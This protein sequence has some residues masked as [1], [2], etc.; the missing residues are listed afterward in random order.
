MGRSMLQ[1]EWS[2]FLWPRTDPIIRIDWAAISNSSCSIHC[3]KEKL[4][5][6]QT[7]SWAL[8]NTLTPYWV[9]RYN[10]AQDWSIA[11]VASLVILIVLTLNWAIGNDLAISS[12]KCLKF[13]LES[14][15]PSWMIITDLVRI[16]AIWTAPNWMVSIQQ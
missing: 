3:F 9:I 10:Q 6:A 5:N 7:P 13:G 12:E 4:W 15:T 8:R 2:K 14:K 11:L 16:F 1:A